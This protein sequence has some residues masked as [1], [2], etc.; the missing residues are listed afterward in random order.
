MLGGRTPAP[1]INMKAATKA[2]VMTELRHSMDY[3]EAA[4][5]RGG[6]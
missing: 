3:G 6:I 4:S 1:V 2:E 5:R